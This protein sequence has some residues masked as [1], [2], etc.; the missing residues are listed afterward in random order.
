MGLGLDEPPQKRPETLAVQKDDSGGQAV[1]AA[2]AGSDDQEEA[3]LKEGQH[4]LVEQVRVVDLEGTL[5]VVYPS[6]VDLQT[7]AYCVTRE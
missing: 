1:A 6:R 5:K 7:E 3:A 4:L 2:A